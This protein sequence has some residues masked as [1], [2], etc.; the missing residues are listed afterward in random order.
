[1]SNKKIAVVHNGIIENYQNIKQD[2]LQKGYFFESS[3]DTEV[4]PHLFYDFLKKG[5]SFKIALIRSERMTESCVS[6]KFK[7]APAVPRITLP[8]TR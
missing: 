8:D 7:R 1:M 5:E 6:E 3:T 2:L 4:I